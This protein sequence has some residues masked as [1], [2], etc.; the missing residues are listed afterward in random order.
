M[1]RS[2]MSCCSLLVPRFGGKGEM[3]RRCQPRLTQN[4]P[5][6]LMVRLFALVPPK[7]Q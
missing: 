6:E 7:R 3:D 1:A 5:I 2:L 4:R